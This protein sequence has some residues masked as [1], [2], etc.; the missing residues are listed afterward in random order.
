MANL[1]PLSVAWSQLLLPLPLLLVF[2]YPGFLYAVNP[3]EINEVSLMNAGG[4]HFTDQMSFLMLDQQC[5]R[6]G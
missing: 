4:G 3:G 2:T 1:Y 6:L 5:Q